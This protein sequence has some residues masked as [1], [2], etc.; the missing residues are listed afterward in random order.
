ME[1]SIVVCTLDRREMLEKCLDGLARQN[2]PV[3]EHQIIVVDN[4]SSDDTRAFLKSRQEI[5][6]NLNVVDEP[7]LGL[8]KARNRGLSDV[9]T[10]LVAFIDDDTVARPDWLANVVSTFHAEPTATIVGGEL[11]PIWQAE[12][13]DWLSDDLLHDFSVCLR[14]ST[15]GKFIDDNE[16]LCEG[17]ISYRTDALKSA[18]GFP[19]NL[20]RRGSNLLSGDGAVR[21]RIIKN[22][23]REYYQPSAIVGHHILAN[24]LTPEWI[25]KRKFWGGVSNAITGALRAEVLDE[26]ADWRDLPIPVL[27]EDWAAIINLEPDANFRRT[28]RHLYSMG[29]LLARGG[30][31]S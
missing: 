6:P 28:L 12:R 30:Y 24:Q 5:F 19:E 16:W 22:G 15:V 18:G 21:F 29:Y 31:V 1:I 17:N 8:S 7:D 10:P 2:F 26:A 14:R 13:P 27:A 25:A 4:G 20:G 11:E 3:W 23:G 9:E